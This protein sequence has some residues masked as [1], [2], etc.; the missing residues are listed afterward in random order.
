MPAI[1]TIYWSSSIL[2]L[3]HHTQNFP[4]ITTII[5]QISMLF[6]VTDEETE[7]ETVQ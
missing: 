3:R 7:A 2:M 1:T 6:M 5:G 4:S